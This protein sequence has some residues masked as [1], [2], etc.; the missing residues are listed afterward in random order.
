MLLPAAWR[1]IQALLGEAAAAY[2]ALPQEADGFIHGDFKADHVL[3]EST[4]R[5]TLI[6]FDACG[7]GDPAYDIGKF[8]ADLAWAYA[9]CP[10]CDL[11]AARAAFFGGMGSRRGIR[12]CG[13]RRLWRLDPCKDR[14][15]PG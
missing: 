7:L 14:G 12:G 5:L 4:G 9:G 8:L 1:E 10:A 13:G 3:V 2:G 11:E 6:D 15:A